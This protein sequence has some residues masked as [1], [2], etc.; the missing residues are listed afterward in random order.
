V[1]GALAGAFG[2]V[3]LSTSLLPAAAAP[4]DTDPS[5]GTGGIVQ[6]TIG[7]AAI[8]DGIALQSDGKILLAGWSY[9]EGLA[10]AR[11]APDGAL[12]SSFGTGGVATGLEV[13]AHGVALQ[14]D[15]KIVVAG[16]LSDSAFALVRYAADG[17]LDTSFGQGGVTIGPP[18]EAEALAI[19]P[20]GRIVVAG[21]GPDPERADLQTF[22][23]A[24]FDS[25]GS[26]DLGFGSSGVVRTSI[27][28]A[29]SA[30]A[31]ALQPDGRIVVAGGNNPQAT[32]PYTAMALARYLPNG[33]LDQTFGSDGVV[34]TPIGA[35][36]TGG[37]D[38][39]LQPDGRIV[40]T[41]STDNDFAV[42]RYEP[43]G[44]LDTTFGRYG[45]T[46]TQIGPSAYARAVALE[47]D[48]SIVVAGSADDTFALTRYASDGKLDT[49]FGYGGVAT[50]R[51]GLLGG[52]NA[53][54][55]QPDGRILSAGWA[56]DQTTTRFVLVRYLVTS[57]TTIDGDRLVVDYGK[58]LT[59]RGTL[60]DR[61]PGGA[62][63]LVRRSCYAF[64]PTSG[65]RLFA[66]SDGSWVV[67]FRPQSRT[68]FWAKVGSDRSSPLTVRVR[69]RVS[70]GELSAHRLRA[71]VVFVRSIA[72]ASIVLQSYSLSARHW[73]DERDATLRRVSGRPPKVVSGATFRL[74]AGP[75]RWFRILLRQTDPYGCFAT[76]SSRAIRR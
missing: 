40:V 49:S 76:A 42:A 41:G 26:R 1:T 73:L 44:S 14:A 72:G 62:V 7:S 60:T 11:Y 8:A 27:G 64:S 43:D 61:Q 9:P 65:P 63:T 59:V 47:G 52:A 2:L 19:Q 56:S 37:S 45:S 15:G 29:A 23:L 31:V 66:N 24:R 32:P 16:R 34:T 28:L 75:R 4:G 36:F 39:A 74:P 3:M 68:V 35:G 5:F 48:G 53:M 58:G 50:N 6:T 54:A 67:R 57:P 70:V 10:L 71:R 46:T 38:I 55:I 30:F 51:I 18:G 25:D 69:P 33:T 20:N 13:A 21:Y 22:T 12:D 17:A